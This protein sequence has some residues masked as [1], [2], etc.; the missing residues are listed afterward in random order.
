MSLK[1]KFDVIVIGGGHAG[2]EAASAAARMGRSTLLITQAINTIGVL[3]CNPAIGGIGKGQLVK[4][5][6]AL[7]GIMAKAID[8]SGIQFRILNVRKGPAVRSTRAQAD[9]KIY[10][11]TI[12]KFLKS[13]KGLSILEG[14]VKD[15]IIKN[16]C[17]KG[18]IMYDNTQ[19]FS[20][21]VILT[22][23]TFLGGKIHIGLNSFNGG[24]IGNNASI[25]LALR[26]RDLPVNISR[27]KTGTPPRIDRRTINFEKLQSQ[28]SDNPLP[29]FSFLGS[30]SEHPKQIP[31]YITHTNEITHTIVN[32]NL[33]LS[34]TYSGIIT[35]KGPRYCPS[36][37]DKVVRFSEKSTHQIFLEP[38]SLS[39]IEIYPNGISTSLPENIQRK[40]VKS[41]IGLENAKIIQPG[42][43]IEY[44]YLDPRHLKLTL[45]SKFISGL[46]LAGQI[47]GTTGYE[48]AAAQGLLAG[49]N[50]ALYS[51]HQ[52]GWFPKRNEAYLGVLIDDLCTKGTKEPYRMFTARAEYRLTLREDNADLRLTKIGKKLGLINKKRWIRYNQKLKNIKDESMRLE[53]LTINPILDDINPL[54]KLLKTKLNIKSN[55]KELLKRPEVTYNNLMSLKIFGP[56][57]KD[58]EATQQIEIQ[59]KYEG[60]IF[61]QKQEIFRYLHKENIILTKIKN[62][63][64]IK[65][66]SNEVIEK[67]NY[68]K[69]YSI[70]QA[71]RISGITPAAISI[72]LI[73]LKKYSKY[74]L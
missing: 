13:Q 33:H 14:E 16:Y 15:I 43:A 67:L 25:D 2:T 28:Y 19:L 29:V 71:S 46:F 58:I 66:L 18:I 62:Y 61:R 60:Y 8:Q 39:G 59:E 17:S 20:Q 53:N 10:S 36:I 34:A 49:L 24:R 40:I 9:R 68:H 23:G 22:T 69:P 74:S 72:L 11:K 64:E 37:E 73:Y 51:S 52:N 6:D 56:G 65:G 41:I 55:A 21:S 38:G 57:I 1:T 44:D 4:E 45:E 54:N 63:H 48:E 70:G 30:I 31:C 7:G 50:A 35:G 27:L 47:N 3:S 5:I 26:L 32:E 42:Y 12:K